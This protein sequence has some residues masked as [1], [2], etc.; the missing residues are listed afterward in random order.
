MVFHV[1]LELPQELDKVWSSPLGMNSCIASSYFHGAHADNTPF[2]AWVVLAKSNVETLASNLY[3]A[4]H[5]LPSETFC[6]TDDTSAGEIY[7][8]LVP[9]SIVALCHCLGEGNIIHR[10]WTGNH[11]HI[12][13]LRWT[14][15]GR[16]FSKR[17]DTL[18]ACGT[19]TDSASGYQALKAY[20]HN[21][22]NH[23]QQAYAYED[24]YEKE[25]GGFQCSNTFALYTMPPL[26]TWGRRCGLAS[27]SGTLA[28]ALGHPVLQLQG[29]HHGPPL[30]RRRLPPHGQSAHR[31]AR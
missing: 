14:I 1:G 10:S 4:V 5:V 17:E 21:F 28:P 11:K 2:D 29:E 31:P 18:I 16:E 24:A 3:L 6:D 26:L 25:A 13:R 22:V 9:K 12:E 19:L 27:H 8:T 20:M 7:P 30:S 23:T 15:C